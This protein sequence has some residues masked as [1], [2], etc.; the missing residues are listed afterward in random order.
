[1]KC[2]DNDNAAVKNVALIALNNPMS[3]AGNNYRQILSKYANVLNNPTCVYDHFGSMCDD[4]M[5]IITGLGD[6]IDVR[7][8][9]KTCPYYNNNDV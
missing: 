6:M 1:M 8:C 7:D 3:C 4:N 5:D 9:F 2:L